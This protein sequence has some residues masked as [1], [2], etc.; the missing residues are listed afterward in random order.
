MQELKVERVKGSVKHEF[1]PLSGFL[2]CMVISIVKLM[3]EE[4]H[5]QQSSPFIHPPYQGGPQVSQSN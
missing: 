3:S 5:T 1:M 4:Y 2:V